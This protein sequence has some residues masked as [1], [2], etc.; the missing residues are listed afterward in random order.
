MDEQA[1]EKQLAYIKRLGGSA[2]KRL[3]KQGASKLIDE[4]INKAPATP[5]QIKRLSKLGVDVPKDLTK[6]KADSLI[7]QIEEELPPLQWQ[8]EQLQEFGVEVTHTRKEASSLISRLQETASATLTQ[9]EKAQ[10]LGGTLPVNCTYEEASRIISDLMRDAD[11]I[12]G[13][14]PTKG[15]ISKIVK[16]GG[17]PS[18]AINTWRADEYIEILEEQQ[19]EFEIRVEDVIEWYF[20]DADDRETMSVKKPSKAIMAKALRFGDAQGWGNN[21]EDSGIESAYNPYSMIEYSIFSVAPDLL[22][23]GEKK[24][25]LFKDA[26]NKQ[27]GKGCLLALCFFVVGSG[28]L[29]WIIS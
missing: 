14:P 21:W 8:I 15:Q 25:V 1:T 12:E 28:A 18:N 24:P 3:S 7:G 23:D 17:D 9:V 26:P 4:L 13:K 11:P 2:P 6:V 16:L 10:H 20:G 29:M 5:T 27:K 22:K 19:D